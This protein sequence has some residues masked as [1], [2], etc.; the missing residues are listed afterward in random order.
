MLLRDFAKKYRDELNITERSIYRN[1]KNHYNELIDLGIIRP[2][3]KVAIVFYDV[4]DEQ[5]L[6]EFLYKIR[7]NTLKARGLKVA[8]A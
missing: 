2:I 6:L 5:R 3:S 8:T 4:V 1:V 7:E